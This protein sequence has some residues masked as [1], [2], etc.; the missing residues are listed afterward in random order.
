MAPAENVSSLLGHVR[1]LRPLILEHADASEKAGRIAPAVIEAL[2]SA[3][4]FH[5]L[6]P[7]ALGGSE[8]HPRELVAIL[9]E[10]AQADASTAWVAMIGS[11]SGLTAAYMPESAAREIFGDGPGV[12][13]AGVVAPKGKATP[14]NGGYRVSGD[15]S[16]ASACQHSRWIG[17][18]CLVE[19]DGAPAA[20]YA[21]LPM[22]EIEIHDTWDVAGLRA[23]GSHDVSARDV[24]VPES[25]GFFFLTGRP[26]YPGQLYRFSMRGLLAAAV[27]SVA[28]GIGRAALDDLRAIAGAKTPAGRTKPLVESPGVQVEYAEAEAALQSGRAFLIEGI[29]K[30]CQT[31]ERGESPTDEQR[32]LVRLGAT[33]AAQ[34]AVQAVDAAYSLA[35]GTSIYAKS[36]LQR[37]FRDMHTLTQHFMIGKASLEAAGR[38]LLGLTVPPGFL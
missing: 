3:G 23:T 11:T 33:A 16:F 25:R 9:E 6:V 31:L 26:Q 12:V 24:F 19:K 34:G 36:P 5:M 1:A 14:V 15:W 28:L 30:V 10:L 37:R 8:V 4:V 13:V 27:A 38:A 2:T 22:S 32:A 18:S 35:G 7:S 20:W 17:L 21:T 29:D